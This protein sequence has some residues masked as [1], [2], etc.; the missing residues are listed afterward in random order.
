MIPMSRP[1]LNALTPNPTTA[2]MIARP[3]K[4]PRTRNPTVTSAARLSMVVPEVG[5]RDNPKRGR[6]DLEGP[7]EVS[8]DLPVKRYIHRFGWRYFQ[9]RNLERANAPDTAPN[10]DGGIDRRSDQ[11]TDRQ[12]LDHDDVE[13]SIVRIRTRNPQVEETAENW[14][15]D[16]PEVDQTPLLLS[17]F[18]LHFTAKGR[19]LWEG[20]RPRRCVREAPETR[21]NI[22][23]G[24]EP[25]EGDV[26]AY[27]CSVHEMTGPLSLAGKTTRIDP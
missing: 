1:R 10:A 12:V 18:P 23:S 24:R 21:P 13:R 15:V 8:S 27:R 7:W 25:G 11:A 3:R 4:L 5:R 14:G 6:H 22:G 16:H 2:V 9:P 20:P 17:I 26:E 19:A